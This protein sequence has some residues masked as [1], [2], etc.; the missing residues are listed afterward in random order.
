MGITQMQIKRKTKTNKNKSIHG[1][2]DNQTWLF[3]LLK[4]FRKK[5]TMSIGKIL[6]IVTLAQVNWKVPV[7]SIA[8]MKFS[9][10]PAAR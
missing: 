10:K 4:V 7:K 5:N 3:D 6:S 9:S 1:M 8:T 2:T